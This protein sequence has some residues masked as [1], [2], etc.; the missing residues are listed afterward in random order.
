MSRFVSNHSQTLMVADE[1]RHKMASEITVSEELCHFIKEHATDYYTL[2]LIL[3]FAHH[4]YAQFDEMAIS[5]ALNQGSER[6]CIQKALGDLAD[7]G[8]VQTSIANNVPLY[9]LTVNMRSLVLEL[10]KLDVR[11]QQLLLKQAWRYSVRKG[12]HIS[13]FPVAKVP[14]MIA[15][16]TVT[17]G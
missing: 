1:R 17:A 9:S 4:P 5:Q 6:H 16:T 10:A 14:S 8:I 15:S 11:Q 7:K 12:D 3:F 2:Q 13:Q